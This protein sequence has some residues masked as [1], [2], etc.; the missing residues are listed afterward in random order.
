MTPEEGSASAA[1]IFEFE[2]VRE[3]SEA[4]Y[5]KWHEWPPPKRPRRFFV[6]SC[7]ITAVALVCFLDWRTVPVGVILLTLE[8]LLWT[9]SRWTRWGNRKG[10][11][12]TEYLHG[13]LTYG[14]SSRGMWFR[15]GALSAESAWPGLGVW[16]E[17]GEDLWLGA[18]GMPR[19]IFPVAALREARIYEQIRELAAAHGVEY[20]SAAARAG[21]TDGT[22]ACHLTG[23]EAGERSL[24]NRRSCA[25]TLLD[26]ARS[27]A[28]ALGGHRHQL[29]AQRCAF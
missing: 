20:D 2:H 7:L 29:R 9:A 10:Y 17:R 28:W 27:L 1:A 5:L 25:A 8:I 14:V 15:G 24:L 19:L 12:L 16:G 18:H 23:A 21:A 26:N 11:Q 3:M 13:P 6:V 22:C 4:E